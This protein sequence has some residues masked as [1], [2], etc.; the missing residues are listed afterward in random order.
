MAIFKTSPEKTLQRD[1]DAAKANV[2]RLAA[3][4][5]A[6][7]QAVIVAKTAVQAAAL[8]GNDAALDATETAERAALH[9]LGSIRTASEAATKLLAH[10]EAQLAELLDKKQRAA[11]AA[12]LEA[13][14]D[15]LIQAE[16]S[17]IV[18]MTAL[19][20]VTNRVAPFISEARGLQIFSSSSLEQIPEASSYVSLLLRERARL[21][22]AG[23]V[24]ATLPGAEQPFVPTI[25]AKPATRRL[26]S[27]RAISW[28]DDT[29]QLRTSQRWQDV[30][31]PLACADR[32]IAANACA[33]LNSPERTTK[34]LRMWP[35]TPRPENCHSLD[36]D[37]AK[38]DVAAEPQH[39][40]VRHSGFVETIGAP[41]KLQIAR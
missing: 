20:A 27:L 19:A 38:A 37:A 33:E 35:G 36:G 26:F 2:E 14:A 34:T 13:L 16:Q 28:T 3:K 10:F 5:A 21:C 29:G 12:E 6:A 8:D 17:T 30:D 1:R 41:Y 23:E 7:E 18:G 24:A 11:T 9:R 39:D 25:P 22:V 4:L 32:A 15:D 40:P 31:L